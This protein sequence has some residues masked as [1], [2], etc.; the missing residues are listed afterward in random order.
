MEYKTLIDIFNVSKAFR[1]EI[2][3]KLKV[4]GLSPVPEDKLIYPA[5]KNHLEGLKSKLEK[6]LEDLNQ[7]KTTFETE[8]R[9]VAK[10]S[11]ERV[12]DLIK[13]TER[14]IKIIQNYTAE[15]EQ[16]KDISPKDVS[17]LNE[18]LFDTT[19]LSEDITGDD[20]RLFSKFISILF[21]IKKNAAGVYPKIRDYSEYKEAIRGEWWA[22]LKKSPNISE[23]VKRSVFKTF[24]EID[25]VLT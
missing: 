7:D 21:H 12:E 13:E 15:F 17:D 14:D 1:K 24:E 22:E 2:N 20:K 9:S 16:N 25:A 4:M 18:F 19:D 23:L 11:I 5:V 6:D 8:K 3:E 10:K